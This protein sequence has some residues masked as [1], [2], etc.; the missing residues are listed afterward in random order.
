MD[1]DQY[2]N[3]AAVNPEPVTVTVSL[4]DQALLS[5]DILPSAPIEETKPSE[6]MSTTTNPPLLS[7]VSTIPQ[8]QQPAKESTQKPNT[9]QVALRQ[10][11]KQISSTM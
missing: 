6:Q 7:E 4:L 3:Q 11:D 10:S 8:N 1:S 9:G 2:L 5:A